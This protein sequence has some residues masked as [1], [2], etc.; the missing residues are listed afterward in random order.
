MVDLLRK[1]FIWDTLKDA[2][3][4][5]EGEDENDEDNDVEELFLQTL[6]MNLTQ[7]T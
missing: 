1:F 6:S 2:G 5:D 4:K 3:T 7:P